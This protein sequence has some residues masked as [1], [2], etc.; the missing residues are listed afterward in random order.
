MDAFEEYRIHGQVPLFCAN[1]KLVFSKSVWTENE[2][3]M[4][5]TIKG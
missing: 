1:N 3:V 4:V 5:F 2:G